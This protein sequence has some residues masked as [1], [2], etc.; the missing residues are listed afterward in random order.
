ML[1]EDREEKIRKIEEERRRIAEVESKDA[2]ELGGEHVKKGKLVL[3]NKYLSQ[4]KVL[5]DVNDPMIKKRF[6]DGLGKCRM[7]VM[8]PV[9]D[10]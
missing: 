3:M 8:L 6:E 10:S 2:S 1:A 5:A 7:L 4:L 9:I